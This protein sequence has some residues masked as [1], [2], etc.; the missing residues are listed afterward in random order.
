MLPDQ[1]EAAAL[2]LSRRISRRDFIN[3]VAVAVGAGG[4]AVRS[5]AAGAQPVNTP[6]FAPESS[7]D[8][9]PP[10]LTGLRG[11]HPGAFEAAHA[12][13][14]GDYATWPRP[15]V[16]DRDVHDLIIVGGGLS[17][18]AAAYFYRQIFG[19]ESR[20][21][22]LDNHDDF[23]G[24]AKR[25]EFSHEGRVF[26]GYGGTMSIETPFPYSYVARSLLRELGI[27]VERERELTDFDLYRR[28][29]LGFGM[30]FASESF[31]E[32]RLVAG[33]GAVPWSEFFSSVPM[34]DAARRESPPA[35]HRQGGP[36]LRS[37]RRPRSEPASR[38]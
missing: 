11:S 16:E 37:R 8:Y 21:L 35:L 13:R 10:A 22:I 12:A 31:A 7:P 1:R 36:S 2:G 33:Y 5:R 6:L 19:P 20:I 14:D 3:G 15:D 30:F 4:A 32:D 23:G 28:H 9:Y 18:L 34:S 27:E 17:G 29:G 24:H 25:N 38:K 26:I